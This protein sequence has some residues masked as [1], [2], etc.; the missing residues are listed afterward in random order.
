M[1]NQRAEGEA[2]ERRRPNTLVQG[3]VS[4]YLTFKDSRKIPKI[5]NSQNRPK[6][7]AASDSTSAN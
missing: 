1:T 4:V 6:T 5:Q 2:V 3:I 7:I